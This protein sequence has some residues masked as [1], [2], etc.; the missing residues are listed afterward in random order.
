MHV[1]FP[2]NRDKKYF[3]DLKQMQM[4]L[5]VFDDILIY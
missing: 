4:N 5:P 1:P 2:S 3:D